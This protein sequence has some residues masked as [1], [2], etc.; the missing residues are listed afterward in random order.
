ML[1]TNPQDRPDRWGFPSRGSQRQRFSEDQGGL[2]SPPRA[3]PQ[4]DRRDLLFAGGR[5][6]G[7]SQVALISGG[8]NGIG[9]A[10]SHRPAETGMTVVIADY[11]HAA[12]EQVRG[13]II[14]ASGKADALSV[15]V[16]VAR[17][18]RAVVTDVSKR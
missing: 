10:V 3:L 14:E 18:V 12:A 6:F 5:R 11:D 15:D 13:E 17:E 8:G 1:R 2:Q 7:V 4:R 9:R 16:T